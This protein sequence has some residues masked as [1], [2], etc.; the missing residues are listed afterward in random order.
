MVDEPFRPDEAIEDDSAWDAPDVP[1][2]K[3]LVERVQPSPQPML[4]SLFEEYAAGTD[5][6]VLNDFAQ[7]VVG[8]L[9]E[10]F[11]TVSAKGGAF[12]RQKE[13][14]GAAN[15]ARYQRDQTLRGH[16]IN[17][18]LPARRVAGLLHRWGSK[19][20][21]DWDETAERLFIAGYML[22]D[23]T[24]VP[25]IKQALKDKGFRE[26]EAPSEAQ[27]RQLDGIFQ[28]WCGLLGL[29]AFLA[30]IGGAELLA[31]DLIY[32]ATNTQQLWGT[33]RPES[34]YSRLHTDARVRDLAA[35]VS[36]L[37][38][39]LAYVAPSPRALV[40]HGTIR[41]VITELAFAPH[42]P[43]M[44]AGRL[45]Y[46]HV[47]ENRGLLLNFIH[48]AALDALAV[49]D[50]RVPFLFA[51]SGVV[52]LERY[53][54]PPMP[55][56]G[57]LTAH[58][59]AKIRQDIGAGMI[60]S[61]KGVK[62]GKDG[63]RVDES[64]NDVFDVRQ[65]I[66]VSPS[67]LSLIRNNVPKYLEKL[68]TLNYPGADDLPEYSTDPRDARLRQMAEWA[69]LLEIQIEERYPAIKGDFLFHVLNRWGIA[70]LSGAFEALRTFKPEQREGTGIRYHWYWAAA[71]A[72]AR[73]PG[74]SP[75]EVRDALEQLANELA[76]MLAEELPETAQASEETWL[77]LADYV[78]GVLTISD[79]KDTFA[80]KNEELRRY[81]LTKGARGGAAC[82]LCG[83]DYRTRK[84][85]ETAV[86]F[87]PGVYTARVRIG[88]SDNKR[89]ICSICGLEQLLRQLFVENL[90]SGGTAEGQRIRYLS[91][92]P[93]YFF[94]PETLALVRRF[95]RRLGNLRLG[96]KDLRHAMS[97][98]DLGDPTFWQRL[99][100]FLLPR[101]QSETK[102]IV[103]FNPAIDATFLMLGFRS[104][105]DPSDTE[106][107][108]VPAFLSLILPV[109]LDI[110]VVASE[111][112]MPLLLE[113]DELPETV[114]FD[115]AHSAI[116]ALVGEGRVNVDDVLPMLTRLAA[117]YLIH[118][119]TEYAPPKENWQRFTPIAH[120]LMESPLYVFHFLKQQER[121]D[122]P[123][124]PQQ[125]RRY[126]KYAEKIFSPTSGDV[127]MSHAKEL[128]R[129]Y[130]Q[131]YRVD[132]PYQA[133]SYTLLRPLDIVADTLLNADPKLFDTKEALIEVARGQLKDRLD[134]SET[135]AY[136]A[137]GREADQARRQFCEEFVGIFDDL[138]KRDVAAL[139]GKQLNL[140][141]AACEVIYLDMYSADWEEK[142]QQ[143]AN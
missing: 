86:A 44:Q 82:A 51:P 132:R 95:Y 120:A 117:A 97:H 83:S 106:S 26:G 70:D 59:V 66:R 118:L 30:P 71:H 4:Q 96:E 128:V 131:F 7:H 48:N 127:L 108:I 101:L 100:P 61:K 65:V 105:S 89:S 8:P 58:I 50:Q 99:D 143:P 60:R 68:Q 122:K 38:D 2:P 64:Y 112:G 133:S 34:L 115:G 134:S 41:K 79:A 27:I 29:D 13:A 3:E 73:Q 12:F 69:S 125:V 84:Q 43:N 23:F 129:L 33:A 87:Q 37:A 74:I 1:L 75:D 130:R 98:T 40:A 14:E 109:C 78:A 136:V 119:D 126:I 142:N 139:R 11:A 92:Y 67:L 76:D 63:L 9:C 123:I 135:K 137:P 114:W 28:T 49:D 111:S 113:A 90:D 32:I 20:L 103:R 25:A 21:R 22:H 18:M 5:D 53:D 17:G 42:L 57:A 102:R 62:L 141:R 19:A 138:Y 45:V 10:H 31:Q 85:A 121:D 81:A 94:T 6:V 35:N 104:F 47:A 54:A 77:D 88:A 107:W 140:L 110:K 16:L 39:L 91:F 15:T 36:H 93:S 52:Y 80:R 55:A 116:R 46:H 72:L 56:P 124:S 24:K